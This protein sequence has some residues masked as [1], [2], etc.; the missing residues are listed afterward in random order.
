MNLV[1]ENDSIL[2]SHIEP[3]DFENPPIIF[4]GDKEI[5]MD[6]LIGSMFNTLSVNNA[7]G[8]AA[9]QIG[10][11]LRLFIMDVD[12]SKFICFNPT[13]LEQSDEEIVG[14]EGCLSFPQLTLSVK[15]P[16]KIH[17]TYQHID[18][19]PVERN[20]EGLAARC[21]CHELDHLNG[22]TFDTKV[23][24]LSL[25]MAKQKRKKL[26]KQQKRAQK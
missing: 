2:K 12:N 17:A 10:Q 14:Q 3:Y 6:I 25:R 23:G 13:I 22:I 16:V 7:V 15:R 8:L 11:K 9:P 18:G 21:F 20:L 26:F 19:T 24:A 5:T 1:N 4:D